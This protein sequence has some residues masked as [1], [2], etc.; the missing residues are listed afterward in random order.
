MDSEAFQVIAEVLSDVA[1]AILGP[2]QGRPHS[3]INDVCVIKWRRAAD[4]LTITQF[5]DPRNP[6][7]II[8]KM[9]V[10][11]TQEGAESF[12]IEPDG[13][14]EVPTPTAEQL[15]AMFQIPSHELPD[16]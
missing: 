5:L 3:H 9:D 6:L 2:S 15:Q 8:I 1:A 13:S 11:P 4:G 10:Q 12:T 16:A 14:V 7:A